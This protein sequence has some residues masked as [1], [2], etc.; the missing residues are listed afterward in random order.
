MGETQSNL[1]LRMTCL[2]A[3]GALTV[4]VVVEAGRR[5]RTLQE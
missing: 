5:V 2:A 4:G 3:G 1:Y